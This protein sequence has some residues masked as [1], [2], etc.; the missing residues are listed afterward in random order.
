MRRPRRLRNR[1]GSSASAVNRGRAF[2]Q[3]Q[4]AGVQQFQHR[5]V[6]QAQRAFAAFRV[7]QLAGLVRVQGLGQAPAAFRRAHVQRRV[8][9]GQPFAVH[10][11]VE[12]AQGGKQTLQAA[13]AQTLAV[14][15]RHQGAHVVHR[16]LGPGRQ[17]G[18]R[19]FQVAPVVFDGMRGQPPFAGQ[20]AHEGGEGVVAALRHVAPG[21]AR[22]AG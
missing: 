20:V 21:A 6:A 18:R 5:L 19:P 13:P 4:P 10:P 8:V 22:P 16:D 11:G 2:S 1:A 9:P 12:G 3:A 14:Q 7:E 17:M 15:P